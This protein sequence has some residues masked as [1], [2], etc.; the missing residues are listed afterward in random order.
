MVVVFA[1]QWKPGLT[2]STLKSRSL[3]L[4]IFNCSFNFY[5]FL[6]FSVK[7]LFYVNTCHVISNISQLLP[8]FDVDYLE[9]ANC[10]NL[11]TFFY[12]LGN[13]G[14]ALCIRSC[15]EDL[16]LTRKGHNG[17]GIAFIQGDSA[18]GSKFMLRGCLK[19]HLFCLSLQLL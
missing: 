17:A 7:L 5:S 8:L 2:D 4:C 14:Q 3:H 15:H 12:P 16:I 10:P 9:I 13:F 19:Y 11:A 6:S 18:G 1:V